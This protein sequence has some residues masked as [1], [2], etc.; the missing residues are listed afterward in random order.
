MYEMKTILGPKNSQN[1]VAVYHESMHS[2]V[3]GFRQHVYVVIPFKMVNSNTAIENIV[4][5]IDK[6]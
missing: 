5:K 2:D 6:S 1:D 4:L 3:W